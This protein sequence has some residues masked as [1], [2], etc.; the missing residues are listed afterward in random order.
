MDESKNL[1]AVTKQHYFCKTWREER[2]CRL[3]A[4]KFGN[5]LM[6]K[7]IPSKAFLT[8]IFQGEN[9]G[10]MESENNSRIY[11]GRKLLAL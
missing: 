6:R 8:R 10:I 5:M 1:E 3:T 7:V 11:R 4:S 2:Q 9:R